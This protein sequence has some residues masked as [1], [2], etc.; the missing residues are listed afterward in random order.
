[1]NLDQDFSGS[2][3]PS[4]KRNT[5]SKISG[6]ARDENSEELCG[7]GFNFEDDVIIF[8]KHT[9]Q[10]NSNIVFFLGAKL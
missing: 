8:L 10:E 4:R 6:F 5:S 2:S 9:I 7:A 1:M 3:N